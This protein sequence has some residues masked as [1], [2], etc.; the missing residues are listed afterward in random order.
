[1]SAIS[2]PISHIAADFRNLCNECARVTCEIGSTDRV[3][4]E[5]SVRIAVR[6][7]GIGGLE[8]ALRCRQMDV[9]DF[10]PDSR[11]RFT[12]LH[13]ACFWGKTEVCDVKLHIHELIKGGD[14]SYDSTAIRPPF[15]C[16]S[17]ALRPFVDRRYDCNSVRP[18]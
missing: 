18:T 14:Y 7:G 2:H 5:C 11:D 4:D 15:D 17:T 10:D 12:A 6:D 9:A 16:S 3:D 8:S 1:M 13:W